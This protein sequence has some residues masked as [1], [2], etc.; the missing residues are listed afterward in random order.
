MFFYK[1]L[2]L[3]NIGEFIMKSRNFTLISLLV[4]VVG[5]ILAMRTFAVDE[6]SIDDQSM[7]QQ[8]SQILLETKKALK[9]LKADDSS[10][11][12]TIESLEKSIDSLEKLTQKLDKQQKLNKTLKDPFASDFIN[13]SFD[14]D[15]WN[16]LQEMQE[17][18]NHMN[19]LFGQAFGKFDNSTH[20]NQLFNANGFSPNINVEEQDNQFVVTADLPGASKD[21]LEINL[22]D[23]MLTIK[24]STIEDKQTKDNQGQMF[25]HERFSGN[26]SRSITLP[27]P[28]T[29]DGMESQVKNG[30]LEIKIPKV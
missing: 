22:K 5:I 9:N 19:Q 12:E 17:M 21:N 8:A 13:H 11:S 20:F 10:N 23:Q 28:V 4:L 27:S 1:Q 30:V 16:P 14:Q 25:R 6:K 15:N 18:Q 26:F 3:I 2:I 7:Q 29:S 24:G